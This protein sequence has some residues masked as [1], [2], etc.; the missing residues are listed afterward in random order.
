LGRCNPAPGVEAVIDGVSG[1]AAGEVTAEVARTV[2]MDR[3]A[4]PLGG[5]AERVR[6][7]IALANNEIF[8]E[9]DES[10]VH[11]GMT[12]VLTLALVTDRRLTIGHVGDSR[13]Y[14]LSPDG[15]RKLT[16][17]HSP[18]GEREDAHEISEVD[19]MCH[20]RR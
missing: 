12:C 6:E 17:D 7:A 15:I 2:I 19:A 10:L 18:I 5:P 8:R 13:L 1:Q 14:K 20:P 3:L 16:H 11:H 4:R 9:A